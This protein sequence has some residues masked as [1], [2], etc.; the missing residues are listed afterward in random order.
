MSEHEFSLIKWNPPHDEVTFMEGEFVVVDVDHK[1]KSVQIIDEDKQTL[2][3]HCGLI[4]L[5]I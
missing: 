3:V 4:T 1:T 5:V 2:W